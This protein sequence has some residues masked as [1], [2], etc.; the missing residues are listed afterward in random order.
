[1]QFEEVLR[2]FTEWFER[3]GIRFAIAG[4]LAIHA[5]GRSRTTQDIDFAIDGTARDRAIAFAESIGYVTLYVSDGYSN[6]EHPDQAFGRVDLMYLYGSTA[7]RV[8]NDAAR[9]LVA[10]DSEAPVPKP[11]HLIAMKVQ[12]MKNA[13]RRVS[14]D[15]PDIEYLL[16]L[17]GIDRAAVRD[18]FQRA[19]LLRILDVIEKDARR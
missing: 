13:P 11:E 14:I 6:H 3:E 2:T 15:V 17:P 7:D 4:G 5:W 12:A 16:T 18:Y 9:R 1:M 19:G 8:F 10:G